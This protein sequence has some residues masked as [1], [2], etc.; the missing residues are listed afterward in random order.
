MR[1]LNRPMFNMGGPIKEG[2]MHGIR[3]PYKGGGRTL[4]GGH[5]IGMPMGNRTGFQDPRKWGFKKAGT[6]LA[7]KIPGFQRGWFKNI[8]NQGAQKIGQLD[9]SKWLNTLHPSRRLPPTSG[10]TGTG[11][12]GAF[13]QNL[14]SFPG[15]SKIGGWATQ[16]KNL[17]LQYPKTTALTALYGGV[18]LAAN[19]PYKKI[20]ST[21]ADVVVPDQIYNWETGRWFNSDDT[22][23]KPSDKKILEE[24][25]AEVIV[26][27]GDPIHEKAVYGEKYLESK[28][29][30]LAQAA[31]DKRLN[32]LLDIMGYD[33]SKS[34]AIHRALVDA[35]QIVTQ[36]PG[37]DQLDITKDIISPIIAA[38]GKR[39]EKPGDIREA[40]GLM[41]AKGE[42]EKDIF[43]SKDTSSEQAINALAAASGKSKK[44]VAQKQLGIPNTVS[45]AKSQ[46]VKLKKTA[47]SSDD[48][49][50]ITMTFA[51]ENNIPFKKQITTDEK[52]KVVGKG[53]KYP[54]VVEMLKAM[55]LD[56][57]GGDDGLYVVG[58][59]IVKVE[60]GIPKLKG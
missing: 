24:K 35:S 1:T 8:Y 37:G 19:L 36:A 42:I 25:K 58:T 4:A 5:Q 52:N 53:K 33:K 28:A 41:M 16:A 56:P 49:T 27:K 57:A 60:N 12:A 21:I 14:R 23:L 38:T 18:P 40:V 55:E 20:A 7:S 13:M 50:A 15:A 48:V 10:I 44:Y 6:Y 31:K 3:E 29:N 22:D 39:L 2:V 30:K 45:E 47:V 34:T 11:Q 54:S 9:T 51:E 17:A 59:S 46:L 26:N 32:K 43:Q